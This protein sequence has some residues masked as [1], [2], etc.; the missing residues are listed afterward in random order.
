MKAWF[1]RLSLRYKLTLAALAVEAVMLALLI[2]NGVQHTR[3]ELQQQAE[4]HVRETGQTLAGAL[5]APLAQR[6]DAS[7]GEIVD[8]LQRDGGLK[9]VAVRDSSERLVHQSGTEGTR[10]DFRVMQPVTFAGQHYGEVA[11]VLSGAFIAEA[12]ARYVRE[13]LSIALAALLVTGVLLALSTGGVIRRFEVLTRAS[14]RMAQGDLDVKLTGEGE[15]EIGQLIGTFNRMA[16]SVRFNIDRA[17]ENEARFHAIADYTHDVEFWLSPEGKLLW[18]NPSVERMLGYSVG[19]C[20]DQMRFPADIIHPDDRGAAEV[21]LRLAL[22]GTSGQGYAMRICRKDGG[23]FWVAVNWQPI[24]DASGVYQGIRAS[25]H[26]IDDLKATEAN[27][28]LAIKELRTAETL[29]RTYLEETEQERA[30]LVSLLSAMNLGI[31]FVAPDGRVIYHNPVFGRMWMIDDSAE[32]IGLPVHEVLTRSAA[33]LAE[34]DHFSRHLRAVLET[35][36]S[37]ESYEIQMTDGRVITELDYPVRDR[38]GRFIGH[39]WIYEDVTRERQ[40]AERLVYLAE[41]DALTGLYNRHRFQQELARTMLDS[42]RQKMQC[43]VMFFDL[44]EFKTINDSYGHRA[45]DALLIRVA[46]EISALVRRNEVLA[47]LGGDE[48]AI[49]LPALQDNEAEALADRV[50]HAIA[51]IPFRFEGQSLRVTTSVGIAYYPAHAVDADDLVARA[52]IA[53]YQAKDAGKNTWRV[54]RADSAADSEMRTR[55][56]WGERISNA[57]DKGLFQLHFQGVYRADDGALSHLEALVRMTDE[58]RPDQLIMPVH[59][60]Q[61]AEKSGR[62]LDIDRWVVHE[63]IQLLAANPCIPSIAVNLSGRSLS[64]PSLP[65]TIGNGLREAG[66]NPSRLIFEITETAAVADLQDAQRMI[67]ALRQ[68]G[69]GVCLDDFGVGFASFAYLKHLDVDT[70]KIDGIFIRD[71]P[72]DPDNQVFV[73]AMVSVALGLGKSVVAEYVEDGAT[74]ALLRQFG[75]DLVQGYYLDRPVA[76]HPALRAEAC[77]A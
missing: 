5:L 6:D 55:L 4:R 63:T 27:L 68:L 75:V 56:S 29:Q 76:A 62:I 25:L 45:G 40:T 77:S 18:I 65:Q 26:S 35:H 54:F 30:R 37:S 57:L 72:N 23:H 32:L 14:R 33:T 16:E 74:L 28:R 8:A 49:L 48:F 11:L 34:P 22:R 73:Q 17:R 42:D 39:L 51:Q 58:H 31:L 44:D 9:M 20:L 21:Q 13:S 69:C 61:R 2:A 1:G 43:A 53:M 47:R 41:R 24:H 19:E 46:G 66:V 71:L 70:I 50:V 38:E 3:D 64:E 67:E 52:D 36:E 59:F 60:I 7:V 12:R 15:D 10:D